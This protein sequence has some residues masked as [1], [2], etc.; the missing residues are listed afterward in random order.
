LVHGALIAQ[1][2]QQA[3]ALFR[4]PAGHH[5]DALARAGE[6]RFDQEGNLNRFRLARQ[7]FVPNQLV[8]LKIESAA[9]GRLSRQHF[10]QRHAIV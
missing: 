5:P 2:L 4:G 3:T 10:S 7:N 8:E 9:Q 6:G 1:A